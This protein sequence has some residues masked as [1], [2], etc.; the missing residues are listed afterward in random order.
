MVSGVSAPV[1]SA[2]SREDTSTGLGQT[3][4]VTDAATPADPVPA[5]RPPWLLPLIGASIVALVIATNVGNTFWVKWIEVRPYAL[6]ALNSSNKFIIG[7]TPNTEWIPAGA[8]ILLRL[9]APDPLFYMVGF[10]YRD[11]ALGWARKV[12]PASGPLFDSVESDDGSFHRLRDVLVFV[13]P[14]NPICLIAGVTAMNLKRFV[15]LSLTGTIARIVVMRG[16]GIAF[17]EQV[18]A[19]LD[20]VAKYQRWFF[21]ASIVSVVGYLVWQTSSHRGLIGGV[22]DLEDELGD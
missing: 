1:D 9:M 22:E 12:F 6:L 15:V 4:A 13:M 2:P 5:S 3:A 7:T 16:I 11:R 14:N 21:I 19:I 8:I 18:D 20:F 10:L 17:S